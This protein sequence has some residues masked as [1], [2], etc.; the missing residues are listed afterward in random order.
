MVTKTIHHDCPEFSMRKYTASLL[1]NIGR[2][3]ELDISHYHLFLMSLYFSSV[4]VLA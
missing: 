2:D 1:I 4:I 3:L